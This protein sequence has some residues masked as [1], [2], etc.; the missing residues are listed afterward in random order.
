MLQ[1]DPFFL[2][3]GM[4]FAILRESGNIPELKERLMIYV[5]GSTIISTEVLIV[6]AFKPS[7]PGHLPVG[8]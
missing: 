2:Y 7:C 5:S 4:T 6:C 8:S 3:I 1:G